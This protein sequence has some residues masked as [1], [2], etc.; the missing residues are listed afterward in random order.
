MSGDDMTGFMKFGRAGV[1]I[2]DAKRIHSSAIRADPS[3]SGP[4]GIMT[5]VQRRFFSFHTISLHFFIS[6]SQT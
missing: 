2:V 5:S 1:V 4:T 6:A 3:L